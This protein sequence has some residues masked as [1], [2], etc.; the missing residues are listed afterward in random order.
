[1]QAKEDTIEKTASIEKIA[2][3]VREKRELLIA[4]L[5]AQNLTGLLI[6]RNENVAWLTAGAVDRRVLLP[7][8]HGVA[9]I[10]VRADGRSFYLTTNNE[11]ERL[12]VEDFAG[13]DFEPVV[14]S[15]QEGVDHRFVTKL[16]GAGT[17]ATD[18]LPVNGL[19][20]GFRAIELARFRAPLQT[21]EI[22]RYRILAKTTTEAVSKVL[23]E[24]EPLVSEREMAARVSYELLRSGVEPTVLLMAAD[25]RIR[26]YKHAVAGD[27]V[28]RRFGMINVCTRR[29]GLCVSMTR[30]VHFGPVPQGLQDFFL[31]VARVNAK[32]LHATRAG[33]TSG[34]LYKIAQQAYEVEGFAGEEM[35]H[36]QGGATG[37]L[38]RE[39]VATPGGSD[40]IVSPQAF[41]WNPSL[42]GAKVEDTVLL[43]GSKLENLTATPRLPVVE[44][45]V[46]GRL[47]ESAGVLL[48]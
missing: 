40:E 22:E 37:Y 9:T 10:L 23:E 39:W 47:F 44:T 8:E 6:A 19:T 34:A 2:R 17:V 20:N 12:A 24:L 4:F 45:E 13:L 5:H 48:R 7:A 32:L 35:L 15:W 18:R 36:H 31:T 27:G 43:N 46:E 33:A 3:E 21:G 38:E 29:W 26:K 11:A 1:M 30:F 14:A 25:D 16:A 28:L 42:R 41:A